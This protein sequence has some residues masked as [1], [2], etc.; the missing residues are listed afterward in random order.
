MKIHLDL[1][2]FFISAERIKNPL[3][4][5]VPAAVGGRG[6]PFIFDR[7]GQRKVQNIQ[8]SHGAFAPSIFYDAKSGF[9]EYFVEGEKIRGIII[10]SSYEARKFGIRT[11]MTIKEALDICPHLI[12]VPPNHLFYH[13]ISS[14]LKRFLSRHI[15]ILEQF[16]IDEF[17]GDLHGWINEEETEKFLL[18][19][20]QTIQKEFDLPIS[21]GAAHS[22]WTAKL[23]TSFAKPHG[24][25]VVRDVESFIENIPVHKFP[26]I[27]RGYL[28]RLQRY[29]ITTLG[30]TKEIE[31]IF[32]SWKKPGIT[33]YKRIWGM[34]EEPVLTS[35][36]KKSIGISRTIDPVSDRNEIVRRLVTLS[37]YLAHSILRHDLLPRHYYLSIKYDNG[38]KSKAHTIKHRKFSETLLKLTAIELF[39]KCDIDPTASIVRLGLSCSRFGETQS[40]DIFHIQK[41]QKMH[42]LLQQ[43]TKI[44]KRYGVN[45]IKWGIE[46]LRAEETAR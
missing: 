11:G 8:D 46:M 16:S 2:S 29:G 45:A 15:P 24:I 1:D 21:I 9:E 27:G 5:N 20:Q 38:T 26:G 19:L 13:A 40:Y 14:D 36:P 28:K 34:D 25:K 12:V 43:A 7:D 6:D 39:K 42:A 23:A 37:R 4:R 31:E 10:T 17:F 3:L 18:H 30:Q 41:D 33:L 35:H 44:R 22:K 32:Y